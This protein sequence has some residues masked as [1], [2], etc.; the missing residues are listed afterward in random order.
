MTMLPIIPTLHSG[1]GILKSLPEKAAYLLRHIISNP[2]KAH[3]ATE[4]ES[5]SIRQLIYQYE[6]DPDLLCSNL[7]VAVQGRMD[8]LVRNDPVSE[9]VE[10]NC[11]PVF[12][13]EPELYDINIEISGTFLVNGSHREF[14][15]SQIF[16]ITP[17]KILQ[18]K[19][20]GTPYER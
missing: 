15:E 1:V 17:D 13:S 4:K 7:Q 2:G 11:S 5:V 3:Q 6:Q 14:Y 19:L 18:L 9:S 16:V 8:L 12:R 10:I 20:E